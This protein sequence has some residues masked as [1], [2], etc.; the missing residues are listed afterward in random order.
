MK[1]IQDYDLSNGLTLV[2]YTTNESPNELALFQD[3]I[4]DLHFEPYQDVP[5]I[6]LN[7][8]ESIAFI[9]GCNSTISIL[10]SINRTIECNYIDFVG[11]FIS[12][13]VNFNDIQAN[14]DCLSLPEGVTD[15]LENKKIQA[16]CIHGKLKDEP[17]TGEIKFKLEIRSIDGK[18]SYK[19]LDCNTLDEALKH[20]K[21]ARV[22][23]NRMVCVVL[24]GERVMRWNKSVVTDSNHWRKV[25]VNAFEILGPLPLMVE[26]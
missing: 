3:M 19:E 8:K 12:S 9:Q 16:M 20:A 11:T 23:V 21:K 25:N 26:S 2:P 17:M 5:A 18:N 6:I 13:L 10:T 1:N 22:K 4:G 14:R 24:N 7:E 15:W